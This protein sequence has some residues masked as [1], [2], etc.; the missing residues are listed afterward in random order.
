M[1][2]IVGLLIGAILSGQSLIR[3]SQLRNLTV[4][5]ANYRTAVYSFVEKYSNMPGDMPNAVAFWGAIAGGAADGYD[6]VCAAYALP[7]TDKR[8]CNGDGDGFVAPSSSG[9]AFYE[10]YR[11]WQH[12][13]NA[14][15]IEGTY[16]GVNN[17]ANNTPAPRISKLAKFMV[18]QYPDQTSG[19]N[20][21]YFLGPNGNLIY[22][23]TN[24][25]AVTSVGGPFLF[26]LDVW[27][28]DV[29]LD[30]GTPDKG[31]IK[32]FK[33]TGTFNPNCTVQDAY[34]TWVYNSTVSDVLCGY[35]VR[36]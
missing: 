21:N 20:A 13:A 4:Q 27:N 5:T 33:G 6:A 15:L 1:L 10:T 17:Q 23:G 26:P 7:N 28:I 36:L 3:A 35:Y 19:A 18:R 16:T 29:K 11:F 12:L 30:D 32:S 9:T 8:T 31:W 2:T 25:A 22:V 24:V 14:G 34:G